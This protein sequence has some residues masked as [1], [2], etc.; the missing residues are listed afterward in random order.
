MELKVDIPEETRQQLEEIPHYDMIFRMDGD[1]YKCYFRGF[2]RDKYRTDT[3]S[4]I[5][6]GKNGSVS[7]LVIRLPKTDMGEEKQDQILMIAR[8][9]F[10]KNAGSYN[11][12]GKIH[13]KY[14]ITG[15]LFDYNAGEFVSDYMNF[16]SE[17]ER[18]VDL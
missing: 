14:P 13:V 9:I 18:K 2:F 1:T 8:R 15:K 17:V 5:S 11:K 16:K 3:T 10:D 7:S 6:I 12:G 4:R